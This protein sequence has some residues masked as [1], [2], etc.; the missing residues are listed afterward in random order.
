MPCVH[1]AG[2]KNIHGDYRT[3]MGVACG[4]LIWTVI[5]WTVAEPTGV[6]SDDPAD[7]FA[8]AFAVDAVK[9]T[10]SPL[11]AQQPTVGI[12]P[13][14]CGTNGR[15]LVTAQYMGGSVTGFSLKADGCKSSNLP[16]LRVVHRWFLPGCL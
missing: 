10:L 1:P 16:V 9:G 12:G 8:A 3:V 4:W 11:G 14:H 7:H 13:T 2:P 5:L 15:F 6:G